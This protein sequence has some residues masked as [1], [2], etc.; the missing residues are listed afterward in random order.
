MHG[1]RRR[2]IRFTDPGYEESAEKSEA[3]INIPIRPIWNCD[4]DSEPKKAKI[5][6]L[7]PYGY[8][9][10]WNHKLHPSLPGATISGGIYL[11]DY[12]ILISKKNGLNIIQI[13]PFQSLLGA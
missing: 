8:W 11:G 2:P 10:S 9:P 3:I 4:K 12:K 1:R 7:S 5:V 6:M 13:K